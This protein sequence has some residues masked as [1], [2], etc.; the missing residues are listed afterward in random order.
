MYGSTAGGGNTGY[1]T[2]FA[3]PV[4]LPSLAI[5]SAGNQIVLSW[6]TNAAS[7]SLQSVTNLTSGSWSNVTS[8]IATNGSNYVY[9]NT[10]SGTVGF[11]R[12]K[13]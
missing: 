9:T 12:L 1:G 2:V 3:M 11:F 4:P 6:P 13:Q 10:P 7:F 8:G 5:A